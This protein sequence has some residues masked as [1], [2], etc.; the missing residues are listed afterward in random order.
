M[1]YGTT[2]SRIYQNLE[3]DHVEKA[4]MGCLR[5]ARN[6]T[7]YLNAA[8]FMRELCSDDDEVARAILDDTPK[9]AEES[10][11]FIWE[12]S[13]ERWVKGRTLDFVL[14]GDQNVKEE[15]K[16]NILTTPTGEIDP[17][18]EQWER[19][20]SDLSIPTGVNLVDAAAFAARYDREKAVHRL[21]IKA[22]QIIRARIKTR[23][24]S[25][26]IQIE[27]QLASQR[28]SQSFL[29]E[30][31]NEVN[32]YFKAHSEDVFLK[33]EKALQLSTSTEPEDASL[34]LT[35]VRRA[36]KASA[37][38]FYPPR[39]GKIICSDGKERLLGEEEYL[40]RL[41]EYLATQLPQSTAKGLLSAELDHLA[42][43]IRRLNEMASKGVHASAT[44]VEAKQGLI[45]LYFFLFNV[46]QH[47]FKPKG[48]NDPK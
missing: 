17:E 41:Q 48:N 46:S 26:V 20:I 5:L 12:R 6:T 19:T 16:K 39:S 35:E 44:L 30:V 11:R 1:E 9:L 15:E 8:I 24:L 27:R 42:S 25:Y 4:V 28:Q 23:C 45:G 2:I 33:L 21:R 22:L 34:L 47:S 31:Q 13:H 3:D 38:F 10:Q 7:D 37:N 36:L 18:I 29:E 43:F 32:N 40:N 14:A